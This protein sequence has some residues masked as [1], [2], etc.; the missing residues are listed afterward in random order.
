MQ[1]SNLIAKIFDRKTREE[2][3]ILSPM[4]NYAQMKE[5]CEE[6]ERKNGIKCGFSIHLGGAG[7]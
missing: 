4:S 1:K 5:I 7:K 2:I 6:I 3:Q